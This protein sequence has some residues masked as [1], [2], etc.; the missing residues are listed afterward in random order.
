MTFE[1]K[2]SFGNVLTIIGGLFTVGVL[3]WY[4]SAHFATQDGKLDRLTAQVDDVR[5][6]LAAAGIAATTGPCTLPPTRHNL[7]LDIPRSPPPPPGYV[8]DNAAGVSAN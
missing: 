7:T 1:A 3:L 8:L 5:C 6:T 2:I 4:L